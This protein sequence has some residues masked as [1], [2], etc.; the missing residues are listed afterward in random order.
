MSG[1]RKHL[2]RI[3]EPGHGRYLT[4]SCYKRLPL[5]SNDRIKDAFVDALAQAKDT[6][7][8]HL[9]AW[10][11]MPEHVH[12]LLQTA[13]GQVTVE[14][15]LRRLKS[16]FAQMVITR[17]EVLDAPILSRLQDRCGRIRFWLPGGGY[18]RNIYNDHELWEK[19]QYIHNNPVR[20]GLAETPTEYRWSSARWLE[21]DR[22][23]GPTLDPL[24]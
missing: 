11:V 8:F 18:D 1:H 16:P 10:V 20:R 7:E 3:E 5:F 22:D 12:L 24:T 2:R 23:W 4:F 14:S 15:I 13:S 6:I 9:Y 21:G 17:W 19:V